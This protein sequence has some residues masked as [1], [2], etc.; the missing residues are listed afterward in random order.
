ML[1]RSEEI[2]ERPIKIN[3][4][5]YQSWLVHLRATQPDLAKASLLSGD[6]VIAKANELM[7]L[8]R[9]TSLEEFKKSGG[10]H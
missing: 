8:N 4:Q 5:P 7:D 10:A 9:F 1:F 3:R 6:A 2:Q